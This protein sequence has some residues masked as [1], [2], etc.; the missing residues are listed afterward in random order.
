MIL[1]Q[2]QA[3]LTSRRGFAA[4]VEPPKG[5]RHLGGGVIV[6]FLHCGVMLAIQRRWDAWPSLVASVALGLVI[7]L[8]GLVRERLL[9]RSLH[10]AYRERGWVTA[11]APTG[12]VRESGE[13]STWL[14]RDHAL[15][16]GDVGDDTEP[17]VLVGGP[18]T[19]PAR[20]VDGARATRERLTALSVEAEKEL[21]NRLQTKVLYRD[22]DAAPHLPVP[23]GTRLTIQTGVSDFVLVIPARAGARRRRPRYFG[24]RGGHAAR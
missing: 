5:L 15:T 16:S 24:I 1:E 12:L 2:L 14:R 20:V 6:V 23:A 9:L 21:C 7:M 8:A 3:E 13:T 4:R 11:Q 17:V 22:Q 10:T 19:D 18:G